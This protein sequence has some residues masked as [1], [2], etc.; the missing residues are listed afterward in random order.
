MLHTKL[1]TDISAEVFSL[2]LFWK[3][4]LLAGLL[5]IFLPP[6]IA[7]LLIMRWVDLGPYKHSAFGNYLRTYM[8]PSVVAMG[9]LGTIITHLGAWY[10]RPFL[11]P[12]GL[13][14][15]AVGWLRGVLWLRE[16]G[17]SKGADALQQAQWSAR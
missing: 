2:Y 13:G 7:S 15:V 8:T 14:L 4:K 11:L 5:V 1:F 10:R 12:V 17:A 9:V 16:A 3:R 6:I